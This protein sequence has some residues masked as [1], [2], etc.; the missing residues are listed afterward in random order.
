M[1]VTYNFTA[2]DGSSVASKVV[3]EAFDFGDKATN[4]AMSAAHK[5]LLLQ[6]FLIPTHDI[7]DADQNDY[8]FDADAAARKQPGAEY[9]GKTVEQLEALRNG[10]MGAGDMPPKE[11]LG[12][13]A[14]LKADA[15][16]K[17]TEPTP[18]KPAEKAATKAP[19]AKKKEAAPVTPPPAEEEAAPGGAEDDFMAG[20]EAPTKA[21]LKPSVLGH[22]LTS[23]THSKYK[24]KALQEFSYEDLIELRDKWAV[25]PKFQVKINADPAAVKDKEMLL[26]AIGEWEAM[27]AAAKK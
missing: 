13:I 24:D 20:A 17:P 3:G 9:D 26:I 27:H 18:T 19:A 14:E 22:K 16:E 25:N 12:K 8:S 11:L 5:Y 21:D 23:I 2:A 6:T 10:I 4:K 7:A 1:T 15:Q